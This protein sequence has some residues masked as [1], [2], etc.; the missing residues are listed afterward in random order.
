M[1]LIKGDQSQ[2]EEESAIVRL[3]KVDAGELCKNKGVGG[4][5]DGRS[6]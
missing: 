3:Q 1:T 4:H 6:P 2:I 5:F